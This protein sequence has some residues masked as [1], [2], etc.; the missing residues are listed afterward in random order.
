MNPESLA[1]KHNIVNEGI[2]QLKVLAFTIRRAVTNMVSPCIRFND[3]KLLEGKP[4]VGQSQSALWNPFDN[5]DNWI[6]TAGKIQ[7]LRIAAKK[8]NGIEVKAN[9]VFSFWKHIGN[10]NIGSG[11]VVGREIREGCVVPTKAGGLCQ[12]SNALYDAALNANFIIIERHRHT[13]IIKGSL[14]EQ[15]RDATVKWNYVDLRFKSKYD[16]RIEVELDAENLTVRFRSAKKESV[17]HERRTLNST[18]DSLNDCYSCGNKACYK[19]PEK[20]KDAPDLRRTTFILDEKW[21]EYNEFIQSHAT[22][23]DY[24]IFSLKNNWLFKSERYNWQIPSMAK[25]QSVGISGLKRAFML[26]YAAKEK[27][28]VFELMLAMDKKIA[29]A[30]AYKIPIQSK[31]VIISQNLLPFVYETGVLGGRTFDVMMTR[32][33]FEKLHERLDFAYSLH[34]ESPTLS[35]FRA[36]TQLVAL[37]KNALEHARRIISPHTEVVNLFWYKSEKLQ[38]Q[39]HDKPNRVCKGNKVLF[40]ASAVG[41]KGA[42]EMKR[43]AKELNL[44]LVVAGRSLESDDFWAGTNYTA[45]DGDYNK[46]AMVV[47]PAYVEN[48]PRQLLNAIALGIPVLSTSACG[49]EPSDKVSILEP[50]EIEGFRRKILEKLEVNTSFTYE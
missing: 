34:P 17:S 27:N 41:R 35:D 18:P 37:E 22:A 32:L 26:R 31:H 21:P 6:L 47:Y 10:P 46:I 36:P 42:Y 16:F 13:K 24:F 29:R 48:Q 43:L 44:N 9:E 38:W 1:E 40:P 50:G 25:Q 45:F 5:A 49:L 2:F 3:P 39:I 12:L 14:A 19:H 4:V 8:L 20:R 11:F 23:S 28:N 7:N 30:A 33:P 15:D